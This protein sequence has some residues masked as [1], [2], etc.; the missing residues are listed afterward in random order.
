MARLD[1]HVFGVYIIHVFVL[2][3]FQGVI[4]D[5]ALPALTKFAIVAIAG[6]I[7]SS[8]NAALIRQ[9]PGVMRVI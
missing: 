3:G 8:L 7:I 1:Q 4:L 5:I 6:L 9:I 2:V